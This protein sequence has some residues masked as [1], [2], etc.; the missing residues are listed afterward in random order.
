V[1][2]AYG[3][4][5]ERLAAIKAKY[6]PSNVFRVNQNIAPAAAP[7]AAPAKA[8]VSLGHTAP[9][10]APTDAMNPRL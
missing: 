9:A 5:Y 3:S 2:D 6:D 8:R 1:R 10:S 4:N 7:P